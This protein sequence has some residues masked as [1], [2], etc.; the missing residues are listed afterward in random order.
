MREIRIG[1]ISSLNY[2]TGTADVYFEDEEGS[3]KN[4]LPFFSDEYCMPSVNDKVL[5]VFQSNSAGAEQG[6]IVGRP[7]CRE[8]MPECTGKNV[9]FKRFAPNAFLS[10]DPRTDTLIIHAGRVVLEE[11]ELR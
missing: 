4:A 9:Y 10:Y 2:D 6:Y 8:N 5:V 7:F 11:T 1:R 3:V